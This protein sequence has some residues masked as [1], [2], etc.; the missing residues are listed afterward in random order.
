MELVVLFLFICLI[1][2]IVILFNLKIDVKNNKIM[3]IAAVLTVSMILLT[4]GNSIGLAIMA[5]ISMMLFFYFLYN[6]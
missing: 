4:I 5:I 1:I 2:A 3:L 6:T